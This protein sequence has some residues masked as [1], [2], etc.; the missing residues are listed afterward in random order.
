MEGFFI[1]FFV[2]EEENAKKIKRQRT[3]IISAWQVSPELLQ[4]LGQKECDTENN[5]LQERI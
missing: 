5:L 2:V 3:M 4:M 1:S